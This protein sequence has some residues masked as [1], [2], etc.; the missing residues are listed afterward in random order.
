MCAHSEAGALPRC[1]RACCRATRTGRACR[2]TCRPTWSG[3]CV[4]AWRRIRGGGG[5]RP[6]TSASISIRSVRS[7]RRR[8]RPPSSVV[9]RRLSRLAGLAVA[10]AAIAALAVPAVTHLREA[11]RSE[12][13]VQIATPPTLHA[14]DFAL[15]P[16]GRSVVFAGARLERR[17]QSA[18]PSTARPE[19]CTSFG[20]NGQSA[21]TVLVARQPLGGLLRV[22]RALPGRYRGGPP[23]ALAVASFPQGG[24][25]NADGT[26]LFGK[27]QH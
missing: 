15:S 3:C 6:A 1:C 19:R 5:S 13:R 23:R 22:R 16:D 24:A 2:R 20:G 11:P 10:I 21:S 26:I 17:R 8:R 12:L 9:A 4:S 18:L 14:D 27:G 7:P 25:W